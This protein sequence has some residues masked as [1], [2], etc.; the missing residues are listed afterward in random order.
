LEENDLIRLELSITSACG[1][2]SILV[3][4]VETQDLLTRKDQ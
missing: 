1:K 4:I 2:D 3:G